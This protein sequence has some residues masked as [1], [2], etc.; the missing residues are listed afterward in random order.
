MMNETVKAIILG[1]G[2]GVR[3]ID[4]SKSYPSSLKQGPEGRPGLDWI[5]HSLAS[6]GISNIYYI[7][8]YHI[9]KIIQ[10]NPGLHYIYNPEWD[11]TDLLYNLM[12]AKDLLSGSC[13]ICYGDIVFI[14][15]I[16]SS[17]LQQKAEFVLWTVC[18]VLREYCW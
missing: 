6:H 8:G 1:A 17:L 11:K 10:A 7:G 13:L 4:P 18:L 5:C 9:E 16:V 14:P 15:E 3:N 2:R 12:L